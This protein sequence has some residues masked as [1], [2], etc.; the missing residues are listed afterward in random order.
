MRDLRY[1]GLD[2]IFIAGAPGTGKSTIAK[3]LH[4]RLHSPLFEFGWIP[5]FRELTPNFRISDT[6]EEDLAFRNLVCVIKNYQRYGFRNVIVTD[7]NDLRNRE[8]Y[9]IFRRYNYLHCTL[10]IQNDA[11]LKRRVLDESRSSGYRDYERAT[12]QNK[13]ILRRPLLNH[14]IRVDNGSP[15][16]PEDTVKEILT[17]IESYPSTL[18]IDGRKVP[19][20]DMFNNYLET[21]E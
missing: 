20:R 1:S 12:W 16:E 8:L 6:A 3:L 2:F 10:T 11:D 15:R 19:P 5:E 17:T 21:S 7:L 13:M 9:R 4:D 14:E 18:V